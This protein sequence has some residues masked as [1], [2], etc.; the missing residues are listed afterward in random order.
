[1][2]MVTYN[3]TMETTANRV[4]LNVNVPE[5]LRD[6]LREAVP[7]RKRSRF[8]AEAIEAALRE[9]NKQKLLDLLDNLP[10]YDTGGEDSVEVLRRLRGE[11]AEYVASRHQPLAQ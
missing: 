1:M 2:V 9:E 11:R 7:P 8:V 10:R 5:P 3:G 4:P 6:R